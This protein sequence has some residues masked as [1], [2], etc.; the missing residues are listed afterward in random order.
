M[1]TKKQKEREKKHAKII[2]LFRKLD[3][4]GGSRMAMWAEMERRT[5]YSHQGIRKVLTEH[6]INFK[7]TIDKDGN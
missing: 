5:G 3:S 2:E 4:Q 7:K 6:G 1:K